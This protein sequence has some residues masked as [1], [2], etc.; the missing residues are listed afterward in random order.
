MSNDTAIR[1]NNIR[2]FFEYARAN[3]DALDAVSSAKASVLLGVGRQRVYDLINSGKL[4]AWSVYDTD[5]DVDDH[6]CV[7][8]VSSKD[9]ESYRSAPKNRGG[10][11]KK[12]LAA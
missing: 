3:P 8:W 11:P 7:I 1:F 6:A 9:I 12:A 2:E 5:S 10:R 4:R